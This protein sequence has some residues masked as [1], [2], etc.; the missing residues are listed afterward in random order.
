MQPH[1]ELRIDP[2]DLGCDAS[3]VAP[4]FVVPYSTPEITRA[5][6]LKTVALT[7]GLDAHIT[8]LAVHTVPFPAPFH[9]PTS[10]HAFLVEQLL[11]LAS[12]CPVPVA[13]Q[14]VLARS[15]EEGF[16]AMLP[17][18]SIVLVGSRRHLWRTEEESFARMLASNGHNVA[19]LHID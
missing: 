4:Y 8:L 17:P 3:P 7:A 1:G 15:R 11:E 6:L 13:P 19:L 2:A 9:C 18:E 5:L 10:T 14:V 12:E 16:C